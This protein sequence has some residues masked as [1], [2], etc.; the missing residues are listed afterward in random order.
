MNFYKISLI[1][2]SFFLT[3]F[4][5]ESNKV[6]S[7]VSSCN[8]ED[9]TYKENLSSEVSNYIRFFN[10]NGNVVEFIAEMPHDAH[11]KMKIEGNKLTVFECS[12]AT[13]NFTLLEDCAAIA[14]SFKLK[15]MNLVDVVNYKR[16][17]R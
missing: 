8:L 13:G 1:G 17:K 2:I 11:G 6:P 9:V 4:N 12:V 7:S 3:A 10:H 15:S 16:K 14:G 5:F